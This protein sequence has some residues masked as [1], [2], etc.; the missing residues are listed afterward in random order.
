MHTQMLGIIQFIISVLEVSLC[1]Y[2][3]FITVIEKDLLSKR[4]NLILWI[5]V[6]VSGTLLGLNRNIL[7]FSNVMLFVVIT[8][9]TLTAI[10]IERKKKM[11]CF[12]IVSMYHLLLSLFD[13]LFAFI[14]MVF[15]KQ[16]FE[17]IVFWYTNSG[18]K[19]TIYIFSRILIG[20]CVLGLKQNVAKKIKITEFRK[21]L[22]VI[23]IVLFVLV[24]EYH[25]K[26]EALSRGDV[27][28]KV[29]ITSISLLSILVIAMII[30]VLVT[31]NIMI[32][33]ENEI[34][35][36]RDELIRQNYLELEESYEQSRRLIH[37]MKNH[38]LILKNYEQQKN[39]E[40]IRD[41]LMEVEKSYKETTIHSWTG[42]H[43]VDLIIEQKHKLAKGKG[44]EYQVNIVPVQS[45][46]LN[47]SELCS[48]FG[49]LLDNAIEAC[50][51]IENG[52]KTIWIE[53]KKQGQLLFIKVE[54][55]ISEIPI[56]RNNRPISNKTDNKNHGYGVKNVDRIIKKYDG[57]ILYQVKNN[58][59]QVNITF[60]TT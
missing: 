32:Q 24:K 22:I 11:I 21:V 42:N 4:E 40:G 48:L 18:W 8:L 2:V 14:S 23:D 50:E 45:W 17:Q 39:Y 53:V 44:I 6:L 1:N 9:S 5:N 15:L 10:Y 36:V 56:M 28:I 25:S 60:F 58:V 46:N 33:K 49:N 55:T 29:G 57:E 12:L 19:C 26:L 38:F 37:D 34:L 54:N 30:L 35:I 43:I 59:F 13:F 31:K 16:E 3:L 27:S 20:L 51:K 7:F 47:D 41:Y 52:D